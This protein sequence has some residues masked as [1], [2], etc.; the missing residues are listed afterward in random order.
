MLKKLGRRQIGKTSRKLWK[1]CTHQSLLKYTQPVICIE[2]NDQM[3]FSCFFLLSH[4]LTCLFILNF[5]LPLHGLAHDVWVHTQNEDQDTGSPDS[6][7]YR[8]IL[9]VYSWQLSKIYRRITKEERDPEGLYAIK[10]CLTKLLSKQTEFLHVLK[11]HWN[12][13]KSIS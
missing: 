5:Q 8:F 13:Q 3:K 9:D 4:F 10:T 6:N 12:L 7:I 1:K 11:S 2:K